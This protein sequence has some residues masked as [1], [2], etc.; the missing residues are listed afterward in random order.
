MQAKQRN[1]GRRFGASKIH[2]SPPV[3]LGYCAFLGSGSV[4]V[5]LLFYAS[6]IVCRGSVL[7]F[8]LVCVTLCPF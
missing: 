7:V 8:D 3:S 1:P 4:V 2:L 5:N 6:P